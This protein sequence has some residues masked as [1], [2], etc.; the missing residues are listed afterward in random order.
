[1]T[2]VTF[3]KYTFQVEKYKLISRGGARINESQAFLRML[4]RH[5]ILLYQHACFVA[6]FPRKFSFV[7]GGP[8]V[9]QILEEAIQA[10]QRRAEQIRQGI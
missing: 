2:L 7:R 4:L 8:E 10:R 6:L 3:E 9:L 5:L 1:M